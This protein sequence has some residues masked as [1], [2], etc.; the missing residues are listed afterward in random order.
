MLHLYGLWPGVDYTMHDMGWHD[1]SACGEK[2]GDV[3]GLING[4]QR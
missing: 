4:R 1:E 2:P 3:R